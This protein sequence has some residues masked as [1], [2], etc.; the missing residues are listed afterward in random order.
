MNSEIQVHLENDPNIIRWLE[1]IRQCWVSDY[2]YPNETEVD[3]LGR[4]IDESHAFAKGFVIV[5]MTDIW[6][7]WEHNDRILS[8]IK[9][10]GCTRI[11]G[12]GFLYEEELYL[13]ANVEGAEIGRL[14][15]LY[16][17]YCLLAPRDEQFIILH[18]NFEYW[19][20]AGP[21]KLV[22]EML[23]TSL[24]TAFATFIATTVTAADPGDEPG[25][26]FASDIASRY[27]R[28]NERILATP[29]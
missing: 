19:I 12:Q 13:S 8:V 15:F 25:P 16:F 11:Y 2:L 27:L 6:A 21:I 9:N 1:E 20:L 17:R 18:T 5:P 14:M 10:I 3:H 29:T 26:L 4:V 22:Q 28:H 24:E 7:P 23:G